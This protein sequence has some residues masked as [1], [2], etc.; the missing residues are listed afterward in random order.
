MLGDRPGRTVRAP[1]V[2]WKDGESRQRGDEVATEE[3]LEI[4]VI[5]EGQRGLVRHSVAVTMRTPG[6]DFELAAGF[7]LAEGVV[8]E[9]QEI[10]NI[11][12]CT[13]PEEAQQYNIVNVSLRSGA[14]FDAE[15][16]SRHVYTSSS[17]GICGKASLEQ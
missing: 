5:V 12:Y 8:T 1:I 17:C 4:R 3:P 14:P 11:A 16:L 15:R 9:R 7:L 6:N 2:V 13:D 10:G